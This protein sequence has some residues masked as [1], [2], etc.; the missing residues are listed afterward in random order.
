LVQLALYIR[1]KTLPLSQNRWYILFLWP[2]TA[3]LAGFISCRFTTGPV[4]RITIA[5]L[6]YPGL[7]FISRQ[8]RVKDWKTLQSLYQ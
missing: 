1:K 7:V 8:L 2:A 4:S 5:L 3:T 6:I